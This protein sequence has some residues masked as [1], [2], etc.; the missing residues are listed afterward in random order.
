MFRVLVR[1]IVG[2]RLELRSVLRL[3]LGLGPYG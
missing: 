2:V 3:G 1:V